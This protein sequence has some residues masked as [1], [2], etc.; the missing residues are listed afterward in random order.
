MAP[1]PNLMLAAAAMQ[2]ERILLGN[3]CNTLP[4]HQPV[5]LAEEC[6]MLDQMTRGR[7]QIG[8]GRGVQP[9]EFSRQGRDMAL[10]RE[11]F[12]ESAEMLVQLFSQQGATAAG[13]H[14]RF[15]DVT[16]MPSVLQRPTPP[17]WFAG[18][19]ESSIRWAAEHGM[20]FVT[21]FV[22]NDRLEEIGAFYREH[23]VPSHHTPEPYFGVMRHVYVSES[24]ASARAEV[25][26]LYDRLF[27]AWLDVALTDANNVPASYKAYPDMHR[28]LGAMRLDDL[29]AE[30]LVLFG[31]PDEV[32]EAV[33]DLS[34]RNVD[35]LLLWVSPKDVALPLVDACIER[36]AREV[37]PRFA[38]AEVGR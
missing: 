17:I 26:E 4:F 19:S 34:T 33:A 18:M 20:P 2:T 3:M 16:L 32:G 24:D 38:E 1:S 29:L 35:M 14:W 6:A 22:T 8:I 11:M 27:S 28:R 25:G 15:E 9:L 21:S 7:L 30:G 37:M 23:F 5:R 31:G 36:F 13:E 12:E 10:S